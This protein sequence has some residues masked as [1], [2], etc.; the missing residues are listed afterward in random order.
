MFDIA[1]RFSK[2]VNFTTQHPYLTFELQAVPLNRGHTRDACSLHTIV[3]YERMQAAYDRMQAAYDRMQAAYDR[4]QVAYDR[5]HPAC[6][7][8]TIVCI[9]STLEHTR[10]GSHL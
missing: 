2:V 10:S 3:K 7:L 4:M 9:R 6:R 8:H 5:M 1:V